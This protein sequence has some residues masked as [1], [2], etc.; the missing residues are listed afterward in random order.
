M[1]FAIVLLVCLAT[2]A[3]IGNNE[4]LA[5]CA[6]TLG[7]TVA[8]YSLY[9]SDWYF[10]IIDALGLYGYGALTPF[11]AVCLLYC[12]PG[13]LAARLVVLSCALVFV[14]I[15][16]W[17]IGDVVYQGVMWLSLVFQLWLMAGRRMLN[18]ISGALARPGIAR[19]HRATTHTSEAQ[20]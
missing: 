10:P 18:G 4:R 12:V 13:Q 20:P 3:N 9:F 15:V 19:A 16:G 6:V 14:N 2:L 7:V 8:S 5:A 1:I 17:L 11:V